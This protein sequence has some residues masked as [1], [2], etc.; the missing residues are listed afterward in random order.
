MCTVER[1]NLVWTVIS[2]TVRCRMLKL[3]S[4]LD[5]TFDLVIVTLP[6]RALSGLCLR[7]CKV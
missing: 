1:I 6:Y 3:G 7:N 5:S 4:D 2:E